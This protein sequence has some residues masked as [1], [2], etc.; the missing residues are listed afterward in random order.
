ME[1]SDIELMMELKR[2]IVSAFDVICDRYQGWLINFA[3][4]QIGDIGTAEDL[5]VKTLFSVWGKRYSYQPKNKF[6]S[7][8]FTILRNAITDYRRKHKGIILNPEIDISDKRLSGIVDIEIKEVK[9]KVLEMLYEK[10]REFYHLKVTERKS[11]CKISKILNTP[12]P[13]LRERW[14]RLTNKLGKLLK[15]YL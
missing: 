6:S 10:E 12:V 15:P 1:K 9:G 7:F 5:A 2:G 3:F 4:Q 8:I 11:Y 14:H 13:V